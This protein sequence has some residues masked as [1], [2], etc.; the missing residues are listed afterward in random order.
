MGTRFLVMLGCGILIA[1]LLLFGWLTNNRSKKA[2]VKGLLLT[3]LCLTGFFGS[4][5]CIAFAASR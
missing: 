4:S 1:T 3:F 5:L 2:S